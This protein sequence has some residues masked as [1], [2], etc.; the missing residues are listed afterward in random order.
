[1]LVSEEAPQDESKHYSEESLSDCSVEHIVETLILNYLNSAF[2]SKF[3]VH[4]EIT[5]Q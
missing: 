4:E 1:M 3:N 2:S 5:I